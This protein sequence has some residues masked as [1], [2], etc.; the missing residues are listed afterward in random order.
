MF[1]VSAPASR[2]RRAD[3]KLDSSTRTINPILNVRVIAHWY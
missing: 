2:T 3:A 1:L